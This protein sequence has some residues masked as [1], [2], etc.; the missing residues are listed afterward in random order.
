LFDNKNVNSL[1][2]S[3]QFFQQSSV[4][5]DAI[6]TDNLIDKDKKSEERLEQESLSKLNDLQS[7]GSFF[8]AEECK[9]DEKINF[10]FFPTESRFKESVFSLVIV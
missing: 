2:L 9:F 3:N 8:S 1:E 7:L 5:P 4:L 10:Y 6:V